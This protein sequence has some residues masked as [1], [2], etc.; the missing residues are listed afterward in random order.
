MKVKL[1][2][3][4]LSDLWSSVYIDEMIWTLKVL[5]YYQI[6]GGLEFSLSIYTGEKLMDLKE[7]PIKNKLEKFIV[8]LK[9]PDIFEELEPSFLHRYDEN[10]VVSDTFL[11]YE[12][13]EEF[14]DWEI[15]GGLCRKNPT[16]RVS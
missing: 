9:I 13:F 3:R 6:I 10:Y 4:I 11:Q 7:I 14:D 1:F 16:T 8:S 2:F 15:K 5:N 12:I